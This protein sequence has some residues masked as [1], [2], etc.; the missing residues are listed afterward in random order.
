MCKTILDHPKREQID[1]FISETSLSFRELSASLK[2][3][4][5]LSLTPKT[6]CVYKGEYFPELVVP[7]LDFD[8]SEGTDFDQSEGTEFD[9][10]DFVRTIQ[11]EHQSGKIGIGSERFGALARIEGYLLFFV[12]RELAKH[13][14]GKAKL[15]AE[16]ISKLQTI[17]QTL[18]KARN[19]NAGVIPQIADAVQNDL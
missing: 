11:T 17:I 18:E 19:P 2:R 15:P 10:T 9:P 13:A 14:R 7:N 5:G 1:T 8:Q 3:E 4:F 16:Y 12:E 6:L